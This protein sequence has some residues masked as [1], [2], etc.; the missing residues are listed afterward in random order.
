MYFVVGSAMSLKTAQVNTRVRL[1]KPGS[2]YK[3]LVKVTLGSE[4]CNANLTGSA[5]ETATGTGTEIVP[6]ITTVKRPLQRP[7]G[8]MKISTIAHDLETE[9]EIE[10]ANANAIGTGVIARNAM[11]QT[12]TIQIDNF[13]MMAHPPR[14]QPHLVTTTTDSRMNPHHLLHANCVASHM[15]RTPPRTRQKNH[16]PLRCSRFPISDQS[17]PLTVNATPPPTQMSI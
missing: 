12:D 4:S 8:A 16:M 7:K 3:L 10:I 9:T 11:D 17:H 5:I 15:R 13:Q 1:R 6:A 2:D 14:D